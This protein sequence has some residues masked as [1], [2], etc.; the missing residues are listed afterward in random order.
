MIEKIRRA[1]GTIWF[2]GF[3][4]L[5]AVSFAVLWA[6]GDMLFQRGTPAQSVIAIGTRQVTAQ[7]FVKRVQ[8]EWMGFQIGL[9]RQVPFEEAKKAGIV[10]AL[11]AK[12]YQQVVEQTLV[13]LEADHLNIV[14]SD[15]MVQEFIQA[16]P[17]LQEEGKYS[18]RRLREIL[19]RMHISEHEFIQ[20][21]R[22]ELKQ[23]LLMR[24]LMMNLHVPNQIN[25]PI[26]SWALEE[27]DVQLVS[28]E[29]IKPEKPVETPSA[30][31]QKNFYEVNAHLYVVPEQRNVDLL[32]VD[33]RVVS[34][35]PT[36]GEIQ[37]LYTKYKEDG[38]K[39]AQKE[40][41]AQLVA[42]F[43][44][45]HGADQVFDIAGKIQD[46][47]SE[48]ETLEELAQHYN[49]KVVRYEKLKAGDQSILPK[50]F[51]ERVRAQIVQ[52]AFDHPAEDIPVQVRTEQGDIVFVK[53]AGMTPAKQLSFDEV[54]SHVVSD[55]IRK[56]QQRRQLE[57]VEKRFLGIQNDPALFDKL[58]Q[59]QKAYQDTY[60]L[61]R[62]DVKDE[63]KVRYAPSEALTQEAYAVNEGGIF[64]A[65]LGDRAIVGRVQKIERPFAELKGEAF[66]SLKGRVTKSYANDISSVYM[67]AL[68]RRYRVELNQALF[69]QLRDH[70]QPEG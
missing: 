36:P 57:T 2:R 5:L 8:R 62:T 68:Q 47:L 41:E 10:D 66:E 50:S 13:E 7:D 21:V 46:K 19:S 38:G 3:L 39:K 4:F 6:V 18:R 30:D 9:G 51:D 45:T 61:V 52:E 28:M 17:Q 26:Y 60:R 40:V 27:R 14:V 34:L 69:S 12:V 22:G 32:V 63:K 58:W 43:K 55:W 31:I 33:T 70:L 64:R 25:G 67:N 44:R 48:G 53:T 42:D 65:A 49:L 59:E 20:Q 11:F 23:Q 16:Q 35:T 24:P 29:A 15:A 37:S 56:E 1:S 54:Q